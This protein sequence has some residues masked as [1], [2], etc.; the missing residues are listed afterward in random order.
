MDKLSYL[1]NTGIDYVEGLYNQY[2]NDNASV[3][4]GWRRFFEGFEFARSQ[5]GHTSAPTDTKSLQKEISV[6]N[7]VN[8]YRQRG[9][10]FADINPILE[11]PKYEPPLDLSTFSLTEADL[12]TVFQAGAEV[13]LG[14]AKLRDIV[15]LLHATY[16]GKLSVEYKYIRIPKIID[17][18]QSRLEKGRSKGNWTKEDKKQILR[19]LAQA[20]TFE[21]FLHRKFVGQKR[22]S[23]EGAESVIPALDG[24]IVHGSDLGIQE[25][26]IGMAHRGRLNVLTNILQKEY[27]VVFGEFSGKGIADS[28]F[29]GDVKYHMGFSS[30]P[31]LSNGKKVHLSLAPNPSHLEAVDPVVLGVARARM[32]KLYN[33]DHDMICPILIHGDAALAGQGIVYELLQMSRL[34]GY[35]VGGTIHIV[36]NNQV[37]FTT[38]QSDAR[39]ST[40][41]TDVAKVTLSPVF[42]V[43]G[44]DPEAVMYATLLAM[45]FRQEFNRDVFIDIICYRRYGHNEGDEPRFTQPAM[46][47]AIDKHPI[48]FKVYSDKLLA[49]GSITPEELK[50]I[51][52]ECNAHLNEELEQAKH[53][54]YELSNL[55]GRTWKDYRFYDHLKLDPNPETKITDKA[56]KQL[57]KQITTIPA[58]FAPHKTI[59]KNYQDRLKMVE[60]TKLVDWGMGENLAYASLIA[61]GHDVRFSGQDVERG[62][63][64]HRHA[65]INDQ[66][67]N[68]KYCSL[69]T[70]NPDKALLR[71][72]NSLLSE[73]AVLGFEYGYA[74]AVPKSL[75][76]WEAQFGDFANGAQIIID[77]FISASTTKWQ[78]MNGLVM[79]LPHGYEGQG[80]EHSSARLERFL[81]L[82]AENNMYILNASTPANLFHALRRQV[83]AEFRRPLIVFTPKSL[84]RYPKCVS[85]LEDFTKKNFQEVIDDASA[86]P[87]NVTRVVFCTGK[88]FYELLERQQEKNVTNVA[89]VRL[90]QIYPLA[91][92]QLEALKKRYSKAKSWVWAQEEPINMGAWPFLVRSLSHIFPFEVVGRK[93]S[94]SPATGS[95]VRHKTQQEYIILKALDLK[96]DAA[97][98]K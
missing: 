64:T 28:I 83:H 49:E 48:P 44:D 35:E 58:D 23:L 26:V 81:I 22:F 75:T 54:E 16:C 1:S 20:S 87:K 97:A 37:G 29:D 96:P 21:G 30:D 98:V 79:L 31:V 56:L 41:C 84:L 24:T 91:F 52:D 7:L 82:C 86:D 46:Y 73:Y 74:S 9:H 65:V 17:W 38:N 92:D 47:A 69:N 85:P 59:A 80:P 12:D 71:I 4:E 89:V 11:R 78:R 95:S 66:N 5:N 88:L 32:D 19:K 14:P 6:L 63:F 8:G 40:Y 51:E 10:L 42:H 36:L 15:D 61:E 39:T 76:I 27:D 77:Q 18:F 33:G 50:A 90:E 13:G 3:D 94:A 43:N 45:E 72:F 62:T 70:V 53:S 55:Q 67:T 57:A 2:L 34:L 25:F 68:A 93:E 60:E